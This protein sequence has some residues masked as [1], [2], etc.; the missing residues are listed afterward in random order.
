MGQ[1]IKPLKFVNIEP[2]ED[3][4]DTPESQRLTVEDIEIL[5]SNL[6]YLR[7]TKDRLPDTF[8]MVLKTF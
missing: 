2:K 5:N 8:I 7:K 3:G 6:E 4:K 1:K